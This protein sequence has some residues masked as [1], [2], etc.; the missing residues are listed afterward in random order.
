[1]ASAAIDDLRDTDGRFDRQAVRSILPYGQDFLFIDQVSQLTGNLVEA[2]YTI[3]GDS[4]YL[5]SHFEDLPL[6]PGVLVGEAMAQ[7][8]TLLVR[9]NLDDH[10]EKDI[11]AFQIEGARFPAPARPGERLDFRVHLLK[12]R[13][14]VARL[15]GEARVGERQ[16]CKA[17]IVLGIID[18]RDL[19]TQLEA[20]GEP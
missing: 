10:Q 13:S 6:M 18:R 7:A 14:R 9:Y 2:S 12:L 1:M 5:R 11:L 20:L 19:R 3:P 17:R 8:G 16:V 15:E 4:A